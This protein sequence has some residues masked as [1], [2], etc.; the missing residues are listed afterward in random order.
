M[1]NTNKLS[2]SVMMTVVMVLAATAWGVTGELS[3]E[4]YY[5]QG[6]P[7]AEMIVRD[8]MSDA[9]MKDPTLAASILRLHFHDCFVQGCD[10]S[11]LLD[12]TPGHKAEKDAPPNRTLR[13]FKV[14]DAI[15]EVLEEQCP[16]MVSCADILA[17][18]ARDAVVMAGGPYYDVPTGRKD[19]FRS[20]A[21]DTAALPAATLNASALVDL[22]VDRRGFSVEEMVALS[23]GHTLGVAHCANFKNRLSNFDS[24]SQVDPSLEP[25][26]AASLSRTCGRG[27]DGATAP[28][29]M[30]SEAFDTAY[31][32]GLQVN[33]GLLTSDQTLADSPETAMFVNMFAE[34]SDM[35]FYT[36]Q[37]G[38]LKMGQLD[39]K[40]QGD[41]RK[42]CRVLN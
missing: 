35:F 34:N 21:A 39:L 11:L 16:S 38:M 14:I 6:C 29:D 5:M 41:V 37:Q 24:T 3:M 7:M 4:Y 20:D 26:L 12:S 30:T 2:T 27:G 25:S 32:S 19:G 17:L 23:G 33:R 1:A 28:L 15:K 31:F 8:V 13:G 9:I 36:F 42:S 18:A 22:F 40:E 10:A